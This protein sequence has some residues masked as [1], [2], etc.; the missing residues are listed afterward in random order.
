MDLRYS[1]Q[2]IAFRDEV[3][4]FLD[5]NLPVDLADKVRGRRAKVGEITAPAA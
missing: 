3:R 4:E 5:Q 1:E 2:E